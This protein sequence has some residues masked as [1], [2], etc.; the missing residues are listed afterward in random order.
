MWSLSVKN[1]K[2]FK[3]CVLLFKLGM[4]WPVDL[5]SFSKACLCV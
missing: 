4:G 5:I 2:K 3:F 1:S